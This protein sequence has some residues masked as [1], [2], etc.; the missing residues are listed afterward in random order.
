MAAG[1]GDWIFF[2]SPAWRNHYYPNLSGL[3]L[4]SASESRR[5]FWIPWLVKYCGSY[6]GGMVSWLD[7]SVVD[8]S[9]D[10]AFFVVGTPRC[11]TWGCTHHEKVLPD[12]LCYGGGAGLEISNCL[13]GAYCPCFALI[14]NGVSMIQELGFTIFSYSF[15]L[16][17]VLCF[18]VSMGIIFLRSRNYSGGD[19]SSPCSKT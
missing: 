6:D 13:P 8:G 15:H 17:Y 7:R 12:G 5:R 11:S 9:L 4:P 19:V 10:I 2:P 14:S 16:M 1:G 3:N 18:F